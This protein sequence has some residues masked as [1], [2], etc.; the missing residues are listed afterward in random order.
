MEET[1][2][3]ICPEHKTEMGFPTTFID[4]VPQRKVHFCRDDGCDWR[5]TQDG[6]YFKNTDE[7]APDRPKAR[8][9]LSER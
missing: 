8:P 7:V 2:P 3:R 6:R 1:K 5:C 9:P 4:E